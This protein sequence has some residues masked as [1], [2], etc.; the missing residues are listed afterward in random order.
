MSVSKPIVRIVSKFLPTTFLGVAGTAVLLALSS[1][2]LNSPAAHASGNSYFCGSINGVPATMARTPKG[3]EVA[4]IRFQSQ[5]FSS[6]GWSPERR[7]EE[8]SK[9]FENLSSKGMLRQAFLT[10]GRQNGQ[11]IVCVSSSEGSPCMEGGI[12]FTLRPNR[13]PEKTLRDLINVA[14]YQTGP[15]NETTAR[16]YYSLDEVLSTAESSLSSAGKSMPENSVAAPET[17][18]AA[19]M[20]EP[21]SSLF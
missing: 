20:S 11:N 21:G 17:S 12:L 13:S 1:I 7:C 19:P 18:G 3:N 16:P 14:K 15:L 8:V 2:G 10:T 4:V 9:R 6:S 5:H